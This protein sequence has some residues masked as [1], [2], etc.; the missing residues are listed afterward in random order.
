MNTQQRIDRLEDA[1]IN[2][3][4]IVEHQSRWGDS[5]SPVGQAFG[6]QFNRFVEA[7]AGERAAKS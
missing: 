1:L 4:T 3:G 2:L 7:V 5:E 6:L